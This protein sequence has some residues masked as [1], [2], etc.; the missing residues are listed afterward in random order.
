MQTKP[1]SPY[2]MAKDCRAMIPQLDA[3]IAAATTKREAKALRR[4]RKLC[5]D[6]ARWCETRAGYAE[7]VKQ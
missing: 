4:R 5:R 2:E 3:E 1:A 7:G 6:L